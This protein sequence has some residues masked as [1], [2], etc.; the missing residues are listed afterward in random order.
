MDTTTTENADDGGARRGPRLALP[1]ISLRTFAGLLV[2]AAIVGGL[3]AIDRLRGSDIGAQDDR[4]PHVGEL[5]PQFALRDA[6]GTVRELSDYRGQVVWV[7][8]WATWCGPCRRELPDIQRLARELGDDL[9]VLAVNEE[10]SRDQALAFWDELDLDLPLLLD[11]DGAV[12]RQ[13]RLFGLPNSFFIDRAGVL[14]GFQ[15][16]FLTESQMRDQLA[17]VGLE[18]DGLRRLDSE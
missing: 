5:A 8:F 6:G 9:V 4:D 2:L 10:E 17:T 16:G 15:L 14:R 7:N 3:V 11:S 12:G 18:L 1:R 13:Y